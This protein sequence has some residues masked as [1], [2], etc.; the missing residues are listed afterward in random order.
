MYIGSS[1]SSPMAF[2]M[3]CSWDWV[4]S[5]RRIRWESMPVS[6]A[7]ARMAS[8]SAVISRLKMAQV[9]PALA[10]AMAMFRPRVLL[11]TEGRAA[12]ITRSERWNPPKTSSRSVNPDMT[13]A[14]VPVRRSYM[15]DCCSC[16]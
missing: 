7:R 15:D 8:W 14:D 16:R 12:R 5:P 10:L 1:D 3:I 9:W 11:P 2:M 4:Y 13:G 6:P